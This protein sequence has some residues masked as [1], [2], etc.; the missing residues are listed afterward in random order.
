LSA[1]SLV[2]TVGPVLAQ[3]QIVLPQR[4]PELGRS[5]ASTD[6]STA[7]VLNPANLAFLPSSELRWTGTF[8]PSEAAVPWQGHAFA[9]AFP[10]PFSFAT[11]LRLDLVDPPRDAELGEGVSNANYQW[12]TWGLALRAS[13]SMSLGASFERSF[14]RGD[15][16]RRLSSW[17]LG[18]SFRWFDELGISLVAQNINAPVNSVGRLGASYTLAAAVRP[19]GTRAV[20]L[21]LEGKFLDEEDVWVPRA[22][23]GVDLP[24]VGRLRGEFQ[25]SDPGDDAGRAWLASLGLSFYLNQHESSSELAGA[26][27][28]GDGLGDESS[29]GVQTGLAARGFP[30]PVGLS[31]GRYAVRLRLED[32]PDAREH[33]SLLRGL[34]S[35][36]EEPKLDAVVLSLRANPAETVAHAQELRDALLTLR[37]RGK[38]VLCHVDDVEITTLYLCAAA[39]QILINPVGNVRFA[40]LQARYVFFGR[41]LENL[42]IAADV[43]AIGEHKSAPE[44]FT[45]SSSTDVS[46]A[47][48]IDLLQQTERQITEGLAQGRNMTF[49]AV[50]AAAKEGPFL[51]EQARSVGFVDGLAFDDEVGAALTKLVG[52]PTRLQSDDRRAPAPERFAAQPSIAVV[53]VEG[54]MI[55][56]RSRRVPLLETE[57]AGSY[58]IAESLRAARESS[59]V[60][61]VV[62]RIETPGGSSTAADLIW[63]EVQLT[64]KVKPVIVS[65]GGY[66]ASG[67]YYIAAPGTRIFANPSTLTGSI[68][69]FYGKADASRLLDRI[70][71][72]VEVYKTS[73]RA[74]ADALYRPYTT[75]ERS[76]L[77]RNLRQFYN[78][79][80]ERVAAGRKIDKSAVDR[81]AQGR[82]WTGE[83]AQGNGLV[84][85][86][87]GLRQALGYARQLTGLPEDA[88]LIE[89]PRIER[90]LLGRLLGVPGINESIGAE[91]RLTQALP[92]QWQQLWSAAVPFLIY[93][94]HLPLTRLGFV[95]VEP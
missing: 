38:R 42:G 39:D 36:A 80:L 91:L 44:R 28:V 34:W 11:G 57:V 66:A 8:L 53:Y 20:E 43:V 26:G 30:E 92:V 83:Q 48:K 88:P 40:G 50:R 7:L 81:V 23:L 84:D 10:L 61:A 74:D 27:L 64:V 29:V 24:Y 22:T 45:R 59:L 37:K 17:S 55:D 78:L 70:G 46:R 33:V 32:T 75:G 12:L 90:S 54:E 89:L 14:S 72:D 73:D 47:D 79:F 51:A 5:V 67:G 1:L 93:P 4:L 49:A 71:V 25:V 2:S 94:S 58:T 52:R 62:L 60:K 13:P 31:L 3:T 18:A 86:I 16:A 56:G 41:L 35:L 15:F 87:G 9:L 69:V 82:V 19:L 76:Q 21:G 6:D 63:R 77:E 65:M 68:G 85:E 95:A